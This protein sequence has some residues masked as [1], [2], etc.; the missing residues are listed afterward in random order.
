VRIIAVLSH[1]PSCPLVAV[2]KCGPYPCRRNRRLPSFMD[3]VLHAHDRM[4]SRSA[5]GIRA[6]QSFSPD[7]AID[8]TLSRWSRT[9]AGWTALP[10]VSFPSR[11]LPPAGWRRDA[12]RSQLVWYSWPCPFCCVAIPQRV[13]DGSVI[14]FPSLA[15]PFIDFFLN[16]DARVGHAWD[17]ARPTL[18]KQPWK[19]CRT[20]RPFVINTQQDVLLPTAPATPRPFLIVSSAH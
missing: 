1:R 20:R 5:E 4:N 8:Q 3:H 2:P 11:Q 6:R 15:C 17:V 14:V 9:L 7:H 12:S 13:V 19:R 18:E 16:P 10:L